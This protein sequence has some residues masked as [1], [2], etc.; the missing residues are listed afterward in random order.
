MPP[1]SHSSPAPGPRLGSDPLSTFER[2]PTPDYLAAL[3]F[4]F[5]SQARASVTLATDN[6]YLRI[7]FLV[8]QSNKQSPRGLKG[9]V[10]WCS[11]L[12]SS[13]VGKQSRRW[14]MGKGRVTSP[15]GQSVTL[16]LPV[17]KQSL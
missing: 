11:S 13:K 4:L 1:C 14:W 12:S 3:E 5:P 16:E 6:F 15:W 10:G 8:S 7:L 2:Q 9:N 17:Y